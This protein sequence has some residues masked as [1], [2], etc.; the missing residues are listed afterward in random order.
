MQ[1][2]WKKLTLYIALKRSS[3]WDAFFQQGQGTWSEVTTHKAIQEETHFNAS[4]DLKQR[5]EVQLSAEKKDHYK[6]CGL[7][8]TNNFAL[9]SVHTFVLKAL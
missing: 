8:D 7:G 2:G 4:K 6:I 1:K 9:L 3:F 5:V